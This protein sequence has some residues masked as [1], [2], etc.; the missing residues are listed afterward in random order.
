M[1]NE[2]FGPLAPL[3]GT[4]RGD[5]G[6]NGAGTLAVFQ[7]QAINPGDCGFSFTGASVKDPQAQDTPAS[8]V[9]APVQVQ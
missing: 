8:F 2:E 6:V 4:W 9:T 5:Q 7:F 1:A 3:I